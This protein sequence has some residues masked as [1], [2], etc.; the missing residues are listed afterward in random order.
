MDDRTEL[1][2]TLSAI[3]LS[4]GILVE[5]IQAGLHHSV[6][7]GQGI[8]F[9]EIREYVPGDDIRSIDW[10]VTA[11]YD[12][13]FIKEF[14]EERD[15]T[16]YFVVDISGSGGFGSKVTKQRKTLEVL[17]GLAFAAVRNNDRI[18]LLLVSDHVEKFIPARSG[19]KHLVSLFN[20][21]IAHTAASTKTDLAAAAT[22]LANALPRRCS[23]IVLS[24]FLSPPFIRPFSILR[25]RHEVIAIRITD[26]REREL[27]DVGS[28][29][30]EDPETG[31]QLL[32]D[33]SDREFRDR[34]AALVSEADE[35]LHADFA[36]TRIADVRLSTDEPYGTVLNRFFAGLARRRSYGRVL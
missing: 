15:Q 31:E 21:V 7:R 5:G 12:R 14:S 3:D 36:R 33:T 34:Y 13:P 1:I 2:R 9:S 27:P 30:I 11:R 16:F 18:G 20:A 25:R 28:I 29:E 4:T 6:F 19:R 24:D 35:G 10:K 8:E 32:V 22:F 23:V 26:P 17:A